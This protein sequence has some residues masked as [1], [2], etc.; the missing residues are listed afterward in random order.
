MRNANTFLNKTEVV[1][2]QQPPAWPAYPLMYPLYRQGL[3]GINE[4]D[5]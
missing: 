3:G 5:N 2:G 4:E 1:G